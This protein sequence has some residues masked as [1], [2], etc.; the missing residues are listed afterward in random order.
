MPLFPPDL[1]TQVSFSVRFISLN[2]V[3]YCSL[4]TLKLKKNCPDLG[5]N[6]TFK[7]GFN[8]WLAG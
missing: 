5:K 2:P 7:W 4:V 6:L 8:C 3:L 1:G